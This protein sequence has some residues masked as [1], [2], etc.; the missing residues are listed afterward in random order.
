MTTIPAEL[1]SLT[2]LTELSLWGNQLTGEI[3]TELGGLTNLTVLSL[4]GNQLT[5]EIPTELGGLTNLRELALSENRLTG[6]IPT[7][8][9]PD[10]GDHHHCRT[11]R[12]GHGDGDPAYRVQ[13][14]VEQPAG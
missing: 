4:G 13:V 8:L 12:G 1:G 9:G 3:P 2:N 7:E 6:E 11:G 14:C 10:D 5:G